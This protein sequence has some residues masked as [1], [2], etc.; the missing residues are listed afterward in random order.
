MFVRVTCVLHGKLHVYFHFQE[1]FPDAEDIEVPDDLK[2]PFKLKFATV[3]GSGVVS[4]K[5]PQERRSAAQVTYR[6]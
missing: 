4:T 3:K 2:R 1:S 6:L 5:R